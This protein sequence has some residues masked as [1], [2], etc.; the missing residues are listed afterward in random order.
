MSSSNNNNYQEV[1]SV[2]E[3]LQAVDIDSLAER[4]HHSTKDAGDIT[5]TLTTS[6]RSVGQTIDSITDVATRNRRG[7]FPRRYST[8]DVVT[9]EVFELAERIFEVW[10]LDH[11][12]FV[13]IDELVLGNVDKNFTQALTRVLGFQSDGKI[14]VQN[15][16]E[17][18]GVL[19]YGELS[20]KV[21]LLMQF[22]DSDGNGEVSIEEIKEYLRVVDDKMLHRLGFNVQEKHILYYED[23]LSLF[24]DGDRGDEAIKIFCDQILRILETATN[25]VPA[26][27]SHARSMAYPRIS[28]R[29]DK[30]SCTWYKPYLN[31]L[32]QT[33]HVTL[34]KVALVALQIFLWLYYFFYHRNRGFPLSFCFAKG[35]GLNLRI[36]T[37][38]IYFT[39]ARTTMGQLYSFKMIRPFIPLGINIEVHSFIGFS[40]F[41]HSFGHTFGHIAYKEMETEKGFSTAFTQNSLLRGN[42][43]EEKLKGDGKTGMLLLVFIILMTF[44]ALYRSF[45]ASNYKLFAFTHFLYLLWLPMIFLHIP[46][47]WPYF[48]AITALIVAER[49]YDLIQSTLYTTLSASRPCANGITF[50]SVPRYGMQT[51]P[52]SYYR[53]RIPAISYEWHPFSLAGNTSSHHLYFFIASAGDWTRALHKLVSD[54]DKRQVTLV[55]VQGPFLAPASQ[56]LIRKPKSRILAVASGIGITP[57]FSLMATKVTDELNYES[58]RQMYASLF[59]E[60]T[61]GKKSTVD[62]KNSLLQ[63]LQTQWKVASSAEKTGAI[64]VSRENS[65]GMLAGLANTIK[66]VRRDTGSQLALATAAISV[67]RRDTGTQQ[68]L[69]SAIKGNSSSNLTAQGVSASKPNNTEKAE[70]EEGKSGSVIDEAMR[71]SLVGDRVAPGDNDVNKI[72]D[73]VLTGVEYDDDD[74]D[75]SLLKVVWSIRELSELSFY[76]DYVQHLVGHQDQLLHH[77]EE[78]GLG[79]GKGKHGKKRVVVEVEVYLTGLGSKTDPVYMLS[80]TLF[81]LSIA[82]MSSAYMKVHFGRPDLHKIVEGFRPD[83]VYYCGG[84]ALKS[85]LNEVCHD[86]HVPFHPEDFDAGGGDFVRGVYAF[87]KSVLETL[88]IASTRK[89]GKDNHGREQSGKEGS[90]KRRN[91]ASGQSGSPSK[92]PSPV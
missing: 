8:T 67:Q 70:E 18:L 21:K 79:A 68:S 61:Y 78:S 2:E 44:T 56:A 33:S 51:Y 76:V 63:V 52:G 24:Q 25:S 35:F 12:G 34:F 16:S 66:A 11:N 5:I 45:S 47:L 64:N 82:H 41:L 73:K 54:P 74:E 72:T 53:I 59:Q 10:D 69:V 77:D 20:A 65:S 3:G 13:T 90:Q 37:L 92:V 43:W 9:S 7:S 14:T 87:G 30:P 17:V 39:M 88:G 1:A 49:L 60:T 86:L 22:M 57:F 75:D 19:K 89:D 85:K 84:N 48:L 40:L 55:Q 31:T 50:L 38:L 58:D 81:L 91:S 27:R 4:A 15:L 29:L 6:T 36:L 46:Q 71:M 83:E 32:Q 42:E 23:I 28:L 26:G 62:S 80:Q